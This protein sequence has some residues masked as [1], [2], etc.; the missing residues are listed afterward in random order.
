MVS[1]D[2]HAVGAAERHVERMLHCIGEDTQRDGL[3][4]TP[5]VR[6]RMRAEANTCA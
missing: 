6:H 2:D 3:M 5:K 1:E 4:D